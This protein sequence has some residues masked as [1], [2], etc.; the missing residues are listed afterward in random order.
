MA[1]LIIAEKSK[2][3]KAIAEALGSVITIKKAGNFRVYNVP[4]KDI[5]VVPLRGHI[6]S[7]ENTDAFNSWTKSNPRDIITNSNAIEKI[8]I[9]Y[10]GPYIKALKEY[11]KICNQVIIGTDADVEGC[12][13]GLV[14]AFP[15]VLKEN[16]KIQISQMWLSSLQKNEII[17]KFNNRIAPKWSWGNSGEARA[18][19]DA[20]IGFS[21]TREVT[22]TLRP[23]LTKF[24]KTFTSIGRVQTSLLYLIYLRDERIN[25]FV[26]DPYYTIEADLIVDNNIIKASHQSN[27]FKKE[28]KDQSV[29]I[30]QNIKNEKIANIINN[31]KNQI[32][33]KPPNPLNTTKAL[34]L[35]TKNLKIS[36]HQAF[37]TMNALYL[38]QIISYPRTDSDV[39]Q[40][41]F[42]HT[43]FLNKFTSHSEYG[44][45][46][47][48]LMNQNKI[49]PT[50]GK[51]DAGDHPPITPLESLEQSSSRFENDL[52]KRVYNIL[53]R[54]YLALFGDDAT[55]LKINLKLSIKE[56]PF[57]SQLVSLISEGYLKIAPFLKPKYDIELEITGNT[58]PIREIQHNSKETQ[59]PPRYTDTTLLQ[60]ME[61]N[62]LGTKAT[63]PVIIQ[64]LEKRDLI[65]RVQRSF[66]LTELGTFLIENLK[67]I[68]LPFLDP[69]FTKEIELLL[70]EIIEEKKTMEEVV[71]NVKQTF[72]D[73]FD[74][75]LANKKDL[76]EKMNNVEVKPKEFPLTSANCPHCNLAPMK[77]ITTFKKKRFLA[78]S[79]ENC[80][81]KYLSLP[82]KGTTRMLK[83]TCSICNF[84]IFSISA[85]KNNKSYTYYICPKCWN[86]GL[87]SQSGKGFC[88]KCEEYKIVKG[89]CIK[90]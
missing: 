35:L 13:I 83:N 11:A 42:D 44:D 7:Y 90:K 47:S 58:L 77:F 66:S 75:F 37:S 46:S 36:A 31:R 6:L 81:K 85:R 20:V 38:N 59:P 17:N 9:D 69:K 51:K 71:D 53:A 18:I 43:Q 33:K 40:D 16:Q 67:D 10:A 27:P 78:C 55:E 70:E 63:R 8:P 3:A 28:Q 57:K 74:K 52:Q 23:L 86:E 65:S 50:K 4:S 21:A 2:A 22:N 60:L 72:L 48:D 14:D 89:A 61:R 12:N 26:P 64:L 41:D 25:N 82:K 32:K 49:K 45:F 62:H 79:N 54:H 56:E 1:T 84:N 39:Y 24:N 29:S 87:S 73:L 80:E 30:F 34:V 15:Y 88:S 5:Y 19:I 76:I 68:W